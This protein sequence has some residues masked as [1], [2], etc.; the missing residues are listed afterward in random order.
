MNANSLLFLPSF[1]SCPFLP[2]FPGFCLLDV[3]ELRH[4]PVATGISFSFSGIVVL[5]PVDTM[6]RLTLTLL[7]LVASAS[8]SLS[9]SL[10]SAN[11]D[12]VITEAVRTLDLTSQ[13][14]KET[15]AITLSNGGSGGAVRSMHFTVPK[16]MADKVAYIGATVRKQDFS[17]FFLFLLC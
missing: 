12:L 15:V 9:A 17:F 11:Q 1:G 5:P 7:S 3:D 16:E 14:V 13:L 4:W 6:P 8:L 10:D 2:S